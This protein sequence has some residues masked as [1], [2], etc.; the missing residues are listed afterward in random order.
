MHHVCII[1]TTTT[2]TTI[3]RLYLDRLALGVLQ[4]VERR[5]AV[6]REIIAR[7]IILGRIDAKKGEALHRLELSECSGRGIGRAYIVGDEG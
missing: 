4:K 5:I 2:T 6:H 1:T 7:P 3:T